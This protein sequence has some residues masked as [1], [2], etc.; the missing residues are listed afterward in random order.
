MRVVTGE[1]KVFDRVTVERGDHIRDKGRCLTRLGRLDG[2]GRCRRLVRLL[3]FPFLL[4]VVVPVLV[5]IGRFGAVNHPV[6][7][8]TASSTRVRLAGLLTRLL[9]SSIERT[10]RGGGVERERGLAAA[11][12][13][14][15]ERFS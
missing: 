12:A 15:F 1:E 6:S 11:R 5:G 7:G 3:P 13:F 8:G 10:E 14:S 4:L 9:E 2:L